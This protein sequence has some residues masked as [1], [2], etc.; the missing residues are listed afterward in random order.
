[1]AIPLRPVDSAL[2]P[3]TGPVPK[4]RVA[5]IIVRTLSELGVDTYYG[6]PGGAIAS[7]YDALLDYPTLRIINTRHETG[8]VF[9]AMGHS[10][11]GGTLPCV[12]MTAGPGI[13]NAITGL[14]AAHAE[15]IPLIAIGGEVPRKNYGKGALQEG[16]R[17]NLDVLGMVRSV[18]KFSAEVT[19]ARGAATLVRKAV[20][21]ALSGRQ[22]PV[23]ISLPLDIANERVPPIRSSTSVSTQFSIDDEMLEGAAQVLQQ[24]ER[25]V[26]LVG[27][28]ARHPEAVRLIGTVA[29]TLQMPVIT[30]PKAKGLFPESDPL[31]LGV[32]GLGG[33][34]SAT[35]YLEAGVDV[36]LCIGCGLGETGTNSWSPILQASRSFIQIDIDAGQIGKNYQVDYGLVG[37][38]HVLLRGLASRLRR[39]R[40]T[41][42]LAPQPRGVRYYE[43]ETAHTDVVPLKPAW[44][45]S[46]LQ[47][48]VPDDTIYASDIGEHTMFAIHYLRVDHPDGFLVN[49]GLG[50]MGSGIGAAI[51][52]KMAMPNR[53]VVSICGDYGF[54]M[55]GN[56][57][58]T[59][60]HHQIGVV[61]AVMNDAR[62][63]MVES[64]QSRVFGRSGM[65]HSHKVDFAAMARGMGARGYNI[66]TPEDFRALPED[67]VR[68]N[69]P[70]V[71]DIEI[72]P[73]AAF[74]VNGRVSQIRHFSAE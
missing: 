51:G 3:S 7:T 1:M 4:R 17:Y 72:D 46:A 18:T 30:T 67:L 69:I 55:H 8:A 56:E 66:R 73:A 58:A 47:Q 41:L 32:F 40:Y 45:L 36:L 2:L 21:T 14:A 68:S 35:E 53:P 65:L 20:S 59:C 61:F 16:S 23:F 74:P 31:S 22:G 63:R 57:V 42:G 27:S 19:N 29:A 25:G 49:T 15:G 60:V 28:G 44:V 70:T 71:L 6:I 62:M 37:P 33:H 50:S 38:A 26:I 64:G 9:M 11:V 43:L 5:D 48:I 34:A 12:L 54:Q 52:A 10:R 24:A 39:K 13:T